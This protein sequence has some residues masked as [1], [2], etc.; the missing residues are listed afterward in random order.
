MFVVTLPSKASSDP[1]SFAHRAKEAGADI[2]EVR[3]D[4]TPEVKSFK[5][6]LP[7]LFAPRGFSYE[8]IDVLKPAYVDLE[9]DENL[10]PDCHPELVEGCN[11]QL[12]RSHHDYEKTP[13]LGEL[14][15]IVEKMQTD[16]P[17]I[18]KIA[19]TINSYKDLH[20]L[21]QLHDHLPQDQKRVI[22]GMDVKAH[23]NR[24]LSP[25]KNELTYSY[26]DDSEQSAS[27]QVPL[28]MYQLTKAVR[29]DSDTPK[30]FGILGSPNVQSK[31]PL[32]H[33]TLFVE[34]KVSALYSLMLTDDLHDAWANLTKMNIHGFSVTSPWKQEIMQ[35]LDRLDPLAEKLGTVNTAVKEGDE[36]IGHTTDSKG[37]LDGYAC[38]AEVNTVNIIGSGGVVPSVIHAC[39]EAGAEEVRLFAR[40]E[41]KRRILAEQFA[42]ESYELDQ[43]KLHPADVIICSIS[44]DV[45]IPLPI[46]LPTS[47]AIDLRY[48]K[49]TQ[50]MSD[51][52]QADYEVH[53]G[54][55]M[56]LHQALAQF[57]IFTGIQPT[58]KH[59]EILTSLLSS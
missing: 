32:M 16:T 15:E 47:H 22:V 55:P 40:N 35:K 42:L 14:K 26:L 21:D 58:K 11:H 8:L 36:W 20:T 34:E 44:T 51:A 3:G 19:L 46:P 54:L 28:S 27:G 23:L 45:S 6:D 59:E 9:L 4:L 50:F 24:M 17:D 7:I 49:Q 1:A 13:S 10:P 31:S 41:Q 52:A 43:L 53:D 5:C 48:G 12:I 56:L 37:L 38:L 29:L 33:N 25:W 39:Q 2:L 30:L 57:E 18:I